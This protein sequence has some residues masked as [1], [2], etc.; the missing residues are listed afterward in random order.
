MYIVWTIAFA[1]EAASEAAEGADAV[2]GGSGPGINPM[3]M[4]AAF[5][6]VFFFFVILPQKKRDKARRAM[7]SSISKGDR[8]V[9]N[10]GICGTVV[11][12]SEKSVVLRVSEDPAVK[13]EFVRSAVSR[14][15]LG[16]SED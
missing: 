13:M 6:A 14:V 5:V 12:E 3:Y 11:G 15:E 10:G 4:I 1:A 2:T 8:V 9:T 16:D 7:L